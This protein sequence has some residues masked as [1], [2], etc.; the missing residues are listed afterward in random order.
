MDAV[1]DATTCDI[2]IRVQFLLVC[3][4]CDEVSHHGEEFFFYNIILYFPHDK[5]QLVSSSP[6]T[7]EWTFFVCVVKL[8]DNA[9]NTTNHIVSSIRDQTNEANHL[10]KAKTRLRTWR[11]YWTLLHPYGAKT[12]EVSTHEDWQWCYGCQWTHGN[13]NQD[14]MCFGE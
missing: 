6:N 5:M 4:V 2:H 7:N 14:M 8:S 3:E 12:L 10:V 11:P 13:A 9:I 1:D